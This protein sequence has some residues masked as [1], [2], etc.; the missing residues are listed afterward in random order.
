MAELSTDQKFALIQETQTSVFLIHE[1]LLALN[2][3]SGANDFY[4]GPLG[5]L[6]Q[7][8]ERLMKLIICLGQQ[9]FHYWWLE[10]V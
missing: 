2:R 7:G 10:E 1:G 8:F 5:L 3:L 4:H 6:A 9:G